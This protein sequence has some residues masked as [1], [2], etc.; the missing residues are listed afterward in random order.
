MLSIEPLALS[1]HVC[2]SRSLLLKHFFVLF[3]SESPPII[4]PSLARINVGPRVLSKRRLVLAHE[5]PASV[6]CHDGSKYG[7]VLRVGCSFLFAKQASQ[8]EAY[9]A[10]HS[11]QYL[12][13]K[14]FN[15]KERAE[16]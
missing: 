4:R 5:E 9:E 11:C 8:K 12:S 7:C 1:L 10:S 2:I 6:D 16:S 3:R 14:S 13:L 15:F